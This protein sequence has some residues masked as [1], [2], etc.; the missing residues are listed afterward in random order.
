[1]SDITEYTM[2]NYLIDQ[3]TILL[4]TRYYMMVIYYILTIIFVYVIFT[5]KVGLK[6]NIYVKITTIILIMILPH[7][8]WY[9]ETGLYSALKFIYDYFYGNVIQVVTY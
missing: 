4:N 9:I 7:I 1:M 3:M 8:L 6:Q 2:S 5:G